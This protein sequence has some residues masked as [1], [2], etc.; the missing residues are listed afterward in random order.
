MRIKRNILIGTLFLMASVSGGVHSAGTDLRLQ[1]RSASIF[2][3]LMY[4]SDI[5]CGFGGK[6]VVRNALHR[7]ESFDL[8]LFGSSKGEQTYA[9]S[10]SIPDFE[11]RQGR[12]YALALDLNVSFEKMLKSN[13]FG[14]GNSTCDNEYQFPKE[15]GKIECIASR[16][17]RPTWIGEVG[18][19]FAT[20]CACRYDP[21]WGLLSPSVP[22]VGESVGSTV[23]AGLRLDTRDSQINPR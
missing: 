7:N 14:I 21:S 17:F 2:P 4:N 12:S 6:G 23:F 8:M 3:I 20:Y 5:G 1:E 19:R 9:L 11:L 16:A 13:F 15:L 10:F 18:Y 22:G